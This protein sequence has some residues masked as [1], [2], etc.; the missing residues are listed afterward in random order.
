MFVLHKALSLPGLLS[1]ENYL[2]L[3]AGNLND[4][5]AIILIKLARSYR[6]RLNTTV[7]A[8]SDSPQ[9]VDIL[10]PAFGVKPR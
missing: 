6:Y 7:D 2:P 4:R 1:H 10:S 8:G 3:T 5:A 9:L